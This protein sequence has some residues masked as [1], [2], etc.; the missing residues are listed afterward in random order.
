[1]SINIYLV[2]KII[3]ISGSRDFLLRVCLE[4]RDQ[5]GLGLG[6]V[7]D[8]KVDHDHGLFFFLF[9]SL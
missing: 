6:G 3:I 5:V 1:M 9:F 8:V 2:M 4:I 7:L